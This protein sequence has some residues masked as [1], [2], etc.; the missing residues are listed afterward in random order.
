MKSLQNFVGTKLL[1]D[2]CHFVTSLFWRDKPPVIYPGP[3]YF[4]KNKMLCIHYTWLVVSSWNCNINLGSSHILGII[5]YPSTWRNTSVYINT[6]IEN[7]SR[8]GAYKNSFIHSFNMAWFKTLVGFKQMSVNHNY[9]NRS[10]ESIIEVW[11]VLSTFSHSSFNSA[12]LLPISG[13]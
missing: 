4:L 2:K 8:F 9:Q 12:L 13:L 3:L 6:V 5:I 7:K 10:S 11:L 1:Q